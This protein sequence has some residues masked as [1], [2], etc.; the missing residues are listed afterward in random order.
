MAF[1]GKH[2]KA[3]DKRLICSIGLM[4]RWSKIGSIFS[5]MQRTTEKT[6]LRL[7]DN[8]TGY[9]LAGGTHSTNDYMFTFTILYSKFF[10]FWN[11]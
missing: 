9:L 5:L 6:Q 2:R 7:Y 4:T 1:I 10:K 11:I 3:N 8:N